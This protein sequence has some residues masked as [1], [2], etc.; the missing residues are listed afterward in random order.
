[1]APPNSCFVR[2]KRTQSSLTVNVGASHMLALS[3]P[4]SPFIHTLY[5][6]DDGASFQR[7]GSRHLSLD[8]LLQCFLRCEIY[9][10]LWLH[11]FF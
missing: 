2:Y 10:E 8:T 6:F 11:V 7:P 5:S 3:R 4:V 9:F 1:M